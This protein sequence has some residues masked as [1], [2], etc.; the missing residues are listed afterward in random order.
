MNGQNNEGLIDSTSDKNYRIPVSNSNCR[1]DY[2][3]DYPDINK[4]DVGISS[5]N[6]LGCADPSIESD[7]DDDRYY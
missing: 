2:L 5:Y 1:N 6:I 3:T 4:P 7:D